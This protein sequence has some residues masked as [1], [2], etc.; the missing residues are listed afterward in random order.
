[1]DLTQIL[2]RNVRDWRKRRSMSQEGLALE[3]GMKRSYISDI[4]RGTRNPSIKALARLAEAL[5][6]EPEVLVRLKGSGH[7]R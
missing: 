5:Q 6:V 4:E 3:C 2:G 1:M 7:S